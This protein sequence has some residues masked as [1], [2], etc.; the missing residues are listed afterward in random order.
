MHGRGYFI[1]YNDPYPQYPKSNTSLGST[2]SGMGIPATSGPSKI[3]ADLPKQATQMMMEPAA[4][5][6]ASKNE[7]FRLGEN[8]KAFQKR[9]K[10]RVHKI[11]Q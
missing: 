9:I 7:T 1:N 5:F 6:F 11:I 2:S 10:T 8:F 4:I 3:P